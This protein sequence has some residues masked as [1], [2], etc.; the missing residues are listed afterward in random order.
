M[1]HIYI[2][3]LTRDA[4]PRSR[5]QDI[6]G[7]EA[8]IRYHQ[9][10]IKR[11]KTEAASSANATKRQ[12]TLSWIKKH[13]DALKQLGAS[14]DNEGAFL[15]GG[16]EKPEG[17]HAKN[18][19]LVADSLKNEAQTLVSKVDE[20]GGKA[21]IKGDRAKANKADTLKQMYLAAGYD[22]AKLAEFIKQAKA[23]I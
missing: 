22:D 14:K 2:H 19:P 15:I 4:K 21:F 1:V 16:N 20:A 10:E 23:Y 18:S 7:K 6:T 17:R 9:N 12:E 11:L 8:D 5:V 13:E 3:G